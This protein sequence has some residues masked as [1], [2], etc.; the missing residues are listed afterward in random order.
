MR[1]ANPVEYFSQ[2]QESYLHN[3]EGRVSIGPDFFTKA[4]DEYNDW[5]EAWWREAIQNAVDA[6]ARNV[7]LHTIFIAEDGSQTNHGNAKYV[8]VVCDDDGSG[9]TEEIV[10]NKFLVLRESGKPAGSATAGGFGK[11]KELLLFGWIGWQI[12]TNNLLFAGAGADYRWDEAPPRRGTRI[13]ARMPVGKYA[14]SGH[15]IDVIKKSYLPR[16]RFFVNDDEYKADTRAGKLVR[17]I[18]EG[19]IEIFYKRGDK[20]DRPGIFVRDRTGLLM[21]CHRPP[22]DFVG[23]VVAQLTAPSIEML[24]SNRDSFVRE[25]RYSFEDYIS[26]LAK[27]MRS[28]VKPKKNLFKKKYEGSG[29]FSGSSPARLQERIAAGLM[30]FKPMAHGARGGSNFS[31]EQIRAIMDAMRG[32]GVTT[33]NDNIPYTP[34]ALPSPGDTEITGGTPYIGGGAILPGSPPNTRL[35][36]GLDLRP[37]LDM[38]L[39][40]LQIPI[41]DAAHTEA[42]IKQ[43]SWEPDFYI[44]NEIEWFHVSNKFEPRSMAPRLRMLARFWAGLVRFVLMQVGSDR[45]Y[46][47]GWHFSKVDEWS[48]SYTQASHLQDENGEHWVMLNPFVNGDP[49]LGEFWSLANI[50]HVN[51]LY[52]LAIHECVHLNASRS[53]HDEAFADT[54]TQYVAKT[55]NRG[56][57]IEKIRRAVV[58]RGVR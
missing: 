27:D 36:P 26:E 1:W 54:F 14:D 11:A 38:L 7:L 31:P 23:V 10:L 24:T 9:M 6:G 32:V 17:D 37:T 13:V 51:F 3:P 33:D 25:Y 46:G 55:A 47:V 49:K 58:M 19:K 30:T 45:N 52:A 42:L 4:I 20:E 2:R 56:A 21:F 35:D 29:K 8:D 5:R 12:H 41:G 18:A 40:M 16:V 57:A 22:S 50:K 15:A 34:H 44:V 39:P 48:D 28:A 43:I 53:Y